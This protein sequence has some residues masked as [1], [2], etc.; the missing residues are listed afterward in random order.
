MVLKSHSAASFDM[1]LHA[2]VD[3]RP[4][5]WGVMT[6]PEI[7]CFHIAVV[8]ADL[9]RTIATYRRI[10]GDGTWGIRTHEW[11]RLAYGSAGGQTWE[12]LEI[13]GSGHVPF[14]QFQE[15]HGE[16]VQHIGFWTPNIRA[17]VEDALAGGARLISVT[18]DAQGHSAVQLR[19]RAEVTAQQLDGL[20]IGAFMDLGVGGWDLEFIGQTAGERFFNDWLGADYP[21]VVLT[22]PPQG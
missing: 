12:L 20:G 3:W 16:G 22:R 7:T 10:L 19:P 13:T 15:R 2:C 21:R 6:V 4:G 11:G 18:T 9:D 17:S 1:A 8:V 5:A 14:R